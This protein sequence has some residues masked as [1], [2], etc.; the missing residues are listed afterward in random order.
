MINKKPISPQNAL[1][2]AAALCSRCEQAP[3]DIRNKLTSWGLTSHDAEIIIQRL[4]DERYL[5]ESRFA[6]A[7]ARDK[8]RFAGWG[9][10]KIA[11]QLRFKHISDDIIEDSLSLIDEN[12]YIDSL[13]HIISTKMRS[14]TSKEPLQ[15]KAALLR[16]ASSRGFEPTLIYKHLPPFPDYDD[17]CY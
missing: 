17:D 15:A 2:R 10:I 7:F 13:K 16:F 14:L 12:E 5:D 4:I 11:Y 8:F 6:A 9:R 1:A 3:S